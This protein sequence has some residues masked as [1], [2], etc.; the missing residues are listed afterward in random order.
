MNMINENNLYLQL[1]VT[2]ISEGIQLADIKG[3]KEW[4]ELRIKIL[5]ELFNKE[6]E[7]ELQP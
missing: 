7:A 3:S 6:C 5:N 2:I 4:V 1:Y